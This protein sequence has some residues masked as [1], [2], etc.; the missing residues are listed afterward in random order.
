MPGA[1]HTEIAALYEFHDVLQQHMWFL[2]IE[3]D[4]PSLILQS[5]SNILGIVINQQCRGSVDL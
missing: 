2:R 3:P 5:M 1:R 4:R